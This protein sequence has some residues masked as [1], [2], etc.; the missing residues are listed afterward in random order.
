MRTTERT[1]ATTNHIDEDH[2]AADV[3]AGLVTP[4][5]LP[6]LPTYP[7]GKA[8][9]GTYQRL[10]N[11]IP[12]HRRFVSLFLGNCA[13]MRHKRPAKEN[14]GIE[15]DELIAEIWHNEAPKWVTVVPGNAFDYL[16]RHTLDRRTFIFADPPYVSSTLAKPSG[17]YRHNFNDDDHIRL[18]T[19]LRESEAMVMVCSLPNLLYENHLKG[20]RT[21]Q[22][23][24]KT[25]TGMQVE[26]LWMNYSAPKRLHDYRYLGND[27]RERERI[28]KLLRTHTAALNERPLLERI[29]L[30]EHLNANVQRS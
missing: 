14:I 11:L 21:M 16:Q 23:K 24:N 7:G 10:I 22:Y 4:F 30:L 15:L 12:P 2:N 26:Q 9:A 19:E 28:K 17:Y 27:M 13:V 25:R 5:V 1:A 29:A 6:S 8:S 3:G 20:W 18:L